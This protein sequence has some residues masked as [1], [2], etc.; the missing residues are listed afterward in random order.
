[1]MAQTE[2][3]GYQG[4]TNYETWAVNLWLSNEEPSYRYWTERAAAAWEKAEAGGNPYIDERDRRAV[5]IL[6]DELK[7]DIENGN[8]FS[9]EPSLYTDLLNAAIGE[10]DWIDIAESWIRTAQ[11]NASLQA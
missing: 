4:W 7:E 6:A 5:M 2:E 8:P 11:E 10:I 1:M 3:R 9:D